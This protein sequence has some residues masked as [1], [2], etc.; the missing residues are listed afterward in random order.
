[1][2]ELVALEIIDLFDD[3]YGRPQLLATIL[4][5]CSF[6]RFNWKLAIYS[7]L[8]L[9][10]LLIPYYEFYSIARSTGAHNVLRSI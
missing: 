2:Y 1:M 3:K 6:R 7:Q 4:T 8:T 10:L 5:L 9:L